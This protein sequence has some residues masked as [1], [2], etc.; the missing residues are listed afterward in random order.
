M[1]KA[2]ERVMQAYTLMVTLSPGEES[3]TRQRLEEHLAG[4]S[5]DENVLAVEGLKFLREPRPT[6]HRRSAEEMRHAR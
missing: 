5:G 6:R 1:Q 4:M 2:V 3:E